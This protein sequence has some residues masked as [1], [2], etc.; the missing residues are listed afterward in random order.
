MPTLYFESE[1]YHHGVKG[2]KWGVRRADRV[3]NRIEKRKRKA[4]DYDTKAERYDKKAERVHAKK[5]LEGSNRAA[6]KSAAY[7]IKSNSLQKRALK[8]TDTT[9]QL[10][11]QRKAAKL[12]YKSTKYHMKA[13][14][15][16]KA[17]A[18]SRKAMKYSI[19]SDKVRIRAAAARAKIASDQLWL[20]RMNQTLVVDPD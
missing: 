5:D 17:A 7:A 2:M 18:Y 8:E 4:L 3:A 19:K 6:R 10:R 15:L 20:E 13:E 12:N 1:L 14:R 9:K 16:A 11:I